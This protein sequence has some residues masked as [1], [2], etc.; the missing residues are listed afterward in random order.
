M[1][2]EEVDR[3]RRKQIS[4][5]GIAEVENVGNIKKTFNRHLHYTIIK[6]RNVATPRWVLLYSLGNTNTTKWRAFGCS[7]HHCKHWE[8][9]KH[10]GG[11]CSV[12]LCG[13][14]YFSNTIHQLEWFCAWTVLVWIIEDG[15]LFSLNYI[16]SYLNG[17]QILVEKHDNLQSQLH[18]L[19]SILNIWVRKIS[20]TFLSH[21]SN[22][23]GWVSISVFSRT[24]TSISSWDIPFIE[25]ALPFIQRFLP[26]VQRLEPL[27]QRSLPLCELSWLP[28]LENALYLPVQDSILPSYFPSPLLWK[29]SSVCPWLAHFYWKFDF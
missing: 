7:N 9:H 11:V 29:L 23:W 22:S 3:E 15:G 25:R 20:E 21:N 28:Q 4:V 2:S 18:L 10:I 26:V 19:Q 14:L 27:Q 12:L 16:W 13:I 6:D 8:L 17:M 24:L 1:S 5:R